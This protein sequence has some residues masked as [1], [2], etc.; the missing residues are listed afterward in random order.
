[1]GGCLGSEIRWASLITF[2]SNPSEFFF[3]RF[4]QDS[5]KTCK[6]KGTRIPKSIFKNFY[7]KGKITKQKGYK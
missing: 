5:F 6:C 2:P 3:C 1:M 7:L 4:M